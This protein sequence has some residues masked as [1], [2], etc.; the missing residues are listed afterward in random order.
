MFVL[1]N[2]LIG[3]A[4]VL[5]LLLQLYLYILLGRAICSWVNADPRNGIVRFLYAATEPP[6]RLIRRVLPRSLRFSPIDI[7]FLVLFVLVVFLR[8][9]IVPSIAQLGIQLGGGQP[10]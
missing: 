7:A 4:R 8:Y 1:G 10:Y 9:A 3:S 6:L 5:D 2:V